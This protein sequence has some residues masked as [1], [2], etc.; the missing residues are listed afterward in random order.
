M[1]ND[2]VQLDPFN[3]AVIAFVIRFERDLTTIWDDHESETH[4]AIVAA[5]VKG[6][7]LA[8]RQFF[9]DVEDEIAL[10]VHRCFPSLLQ[11]ATANRE[12]L[13]GQ[14]PLEWTHARILTQVCSFLDID[15]AFDETSVPRPNSR[16]LASAERLA[17]SKGCLDD[18]PSQTFVL[19][20]WTEIP[21]PM[22][23]LWSLQSLEAR[24]RH[25]AE[26]ESEKLSRAETLEWVKRAE[27]WVHKRIEQQLENEMCDGIIEA[28]KTGISALNP[29]VGKHLEKKTLE[30]TK[31]RPEE[32]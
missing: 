13:A 31:T 8:F 11:V 20:R 32:T 21:H 6:K 1:S 27:F 5:P 22:D 30:R 3:A 28:G 25:D 4:S 16:V 19:P 26:I 10:V 9:E 15:E 18:E 2:R 7:Y 17:A 29:V 23:G 12:R 24:A 14:T